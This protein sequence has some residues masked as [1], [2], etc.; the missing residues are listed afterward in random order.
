MKNHGRSVIAALLL[1]GPL[2]VAGCGSDNNGSN[3]GAFGPGTSTTIGTGTG[4]GPSGQP[5]LVR[6]GTDNLV[7]SAS[8]LYKK[9]WVAI[10]T[11]ILGNPV[12]GATV[13]FTLRSGRFMKGQYVLPPAPPFLPQSWLQSPTALCPNED[14]NNNGI[15]DAGEDL[16]GNGLLDSLGHSTVNTFGI[17][18]ANG[19]ANATIVYPKDAA[20]WSELTLVAGSG[21]GTPATATFFLVG[22]S[23]DY[24]NLG[25]APPGFF[26]PFGAGGSCANTL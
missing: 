7:E 9:L 6:L 24:S 25:V 21:V 2:A 16:N 20:S 15:L 18:D 12:G 11:D 10:V 4:T 23:T 5:V 26:S 13:I 19:V 14:A 22:L 8:P 3:S 17:S 1:A